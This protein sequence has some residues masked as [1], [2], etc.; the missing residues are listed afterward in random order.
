ML[1]VPFSFLQAKPLRVVWLVCVV[2]VHLVAAVMCP[3]RPS[4][5]I[6]LLCGQ[7]VAVLL[8]GSFG[9]SSAARG[10]SL[11]GHLP[12]TTIIVLG[13]TSPSSDG[14]VLIELGEAMRMLYP[15]SE[16]EL[17]SCAVLGSVVVW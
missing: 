7:A 3:L 5:M 12:A 11:C 6:S 14:A 16:M 8:G 10:S 15:P 2:G 1:S 13:G 9:G 17:N 4:L